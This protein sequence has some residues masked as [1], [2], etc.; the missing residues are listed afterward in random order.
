[1]RTIPEIVDRQNEIIKEQAE[2][3]DSLF[4][5]LLQHIPESE[6]DG[7]VETKRISEVAAKR[8]KLEGI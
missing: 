2:I 3:I 5:L 6:L 1:M 7:Y 4:L 8:E